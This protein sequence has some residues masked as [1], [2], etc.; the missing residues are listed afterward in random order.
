MYYMIM[1][2]LN[3]RQSLMA[4]LR[5]KGIVAVFHYQPLH[6]SDMGLKFGGRTGDCPVTEK[7]GDCLL[8]LPFHYSLTMKDLDRVIETLF[9]FTE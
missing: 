7:M 1:P 4:H 2:S 3:A 6:L 9:D 8:R 5:E